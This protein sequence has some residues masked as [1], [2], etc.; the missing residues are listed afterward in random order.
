M[1]DEFT[2][3]E[4]FKGD[5]D[6]KKIM[7]TA[8]TLNIIFI[9]DTS[10]SMLVKEKVRVKENDVEVEKEMSRIDAVNESF[11]KMIPA[12]R[13][14]QKDCISQFEL[15]IAIM[16]FDYDARWIVEPRNITEYNHDPIDCSKWQTLYS[17][18][19][20]ELDQKLSRK[21]FI[22]KIGK[23]A[24]PYI[25]FLTDGA[26]TEGDDYDSA[27]DRLL[28]NAWFKH[29]QR[30][31]VLMG[32]EAID[33]TSARQAVSRFISGEPSEGII[34]AVAAEEIC[35]AVEA[36]TIKS[37]I[38]A[39]KRTPVSDDDNGRNDEGDGSG[40]GNDDGGFGGYDFDKD[41]DEEYGEDSFS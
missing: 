2:G 11:T 14:I 19:F 6:E 16:T 24:E 21:E 37:I 20:D 36:N 33:S 40:S 22:P 27:L 18:A 4:I 28:E 29:S 17:K 34:E 9:V 3:N 10:G 15:K 26:P 35:A 41:F 38:D 39:T 5:L 8:K 32:K 30:Y 23:V 12:L 31:A 7:S 1:G 25:M 13:E